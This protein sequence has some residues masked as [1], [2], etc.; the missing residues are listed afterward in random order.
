VCCRGCLLVLIEWALRSPRIFLRMQQPPSSSYDLGGAGGVP[1][2]S[3]ASFTEELLDATSPADAYSQPALD[4]ETIYRSLAARYSHLQLDATRSA[5]DTFSG[6][7][8]YVSPNTLQG[9][10]ASPAQAAAAAVSSVYAAPGSVVAAGNYASPAHL[11]DSSDIAPACV[12]AYEAH[13]TITAVGI[14]SLYSSVSLESSRDGSAAPAPPSSAKAL[15][16]S[17]Q[18][19]ASAQPAPRTLT[20][21]AISEYSA[22]DWNKEFQ[23]LL[24]AALS[25]SERNVSE[26]HECSRRLSQFVDEFTLQAQQI[27]EVILSELFLPVQQRTYKPIDA[28]GVAGGVKF[29]EQNIFFKVACDAFKVRGHAFL[30]SFFI[31]P[32]AFSVLVQIYGGDHYAQKAAQLELSGMM[33]LLSQYTYGAN[34]RK[35]GSGGRARLSFPLMTIVSYRGYMLLASSRLPISKQKGERTLVYD[36]SSLNLCLLPALTVNIRYGSDDGGKTV[37]ASEP[38][39]NEVMRLLM[40]PMNLKEHMAGVSV[41][42]SS[43]TKLYGPADIEVHRGTDGGFYVLDTAVGTC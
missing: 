15:E 12:S 14:A 4:Q 6:S 1:R 22:R 3:Y 39:V 20:S 37:Y 31:G 43:L 11:Q 16:A 33:S 7:S 35:L 13:D 32:C 19:A 9:G 10:Y 26:T 18:S 17:A 38:A 8:S 30:L 24:D 40:E 23:A 27:G 41:V 21:S 28:G 29:L 5:L 34:S 2:S 25:L 36:S 42:E